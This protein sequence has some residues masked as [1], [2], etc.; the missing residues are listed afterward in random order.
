MNHQQTTPVINTET[1]LDSNREIIIDNPMSKSQTKSL[2]PSIYYRSQ[3][4]PGADNKI[5]NQNWE[6]HTYQSRHD[7]SKLS[8]SISSFPS[9][10]LVN[11]KIHP[12]N[13]G[14]YFSTSLT[15]GI[16]LNKIN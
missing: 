2:Q 13:F 10:D 8:D 3:D 11:Q 12:N 9:K 6:N 14:N 15:A 7:T 5:P 16:N 4:Q 1:V